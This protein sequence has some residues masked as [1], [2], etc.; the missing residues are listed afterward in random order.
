MVFTFFLVVI[1]I[2]NFIVFRKSWIKQVL[3]LPLG[4]DLY[5]KFIRIQLT[6]KHD[7]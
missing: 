6:V 1:F 4:P 2:I 5:L 7:T 3:T